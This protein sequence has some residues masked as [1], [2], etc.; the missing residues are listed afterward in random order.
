MGHGIA[1][2]SPK[3]CTDKMRFWSLGQS[4]AVFWHRNIFQV[5]D[6]STA[7]A[8]QSASVDATLPAVADG[9]ANGQAG[10]SLEAAMSSGKAAMTHVEAAICSDA[11]CPSI[12]HSP[13]CSVRLFKWGCAMSCH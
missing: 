2:F 1:R 6:M 7:S 11:A 5:Q 10:A 8:Q 3:F 4:E 13:A 9:S 12:V